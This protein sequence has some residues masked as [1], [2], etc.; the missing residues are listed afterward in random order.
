P[1][2]RKGTP[3]QRRHRMADQERIQTPRTPSV[4][5]TSGAGPWPV[6]AVVDLV[7]EVWGHSIPVMAKPNHTPSPL[8]RSR[9]RSMQTRWRQAVIGGL[10]LATSGLLP[11]AGA[12]TKVHTT[13]AW[14]TTDQ[15][16]HLIP[17]PEWEC[18]SNGPAL[19]GTRWAQEPPPATQRD[20]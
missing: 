5:H 6:A 14:D 18:G 12:S 9:R 1:T 4:D 13:P 16:T 11:V 8:C 15:E 17:C 20:Q 19:H 2:P 10:L 3:V 7:M